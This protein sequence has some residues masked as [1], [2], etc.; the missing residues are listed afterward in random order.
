VRRIQAIYECGVRIRLVGN[1]FRERLDIANDVLQ[2]EI[3]V[4]EQI[5]YLAE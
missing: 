2:L 4:V 3:A 1:E 5:K